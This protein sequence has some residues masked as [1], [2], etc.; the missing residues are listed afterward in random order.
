MAGRKERGRLPQ[1]DDVTAEL[2]NCAWVKK[3]LLNR[4]WFLL[5][6]YTPWLST[7]LVPPISI[8]HPAKQFCVLDPAVLC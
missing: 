2:A 1:P 6:I 3:W 7:W 4:Q 5:I 8:T